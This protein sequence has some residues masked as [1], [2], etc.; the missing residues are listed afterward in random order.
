MNNYS[1]NKDVYINIG[2]HIILRI[3]RV[4]ESNIG[5]FIAKI[6]KLDGEHE[7]QKRLEI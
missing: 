2:L 1:K 6:W 4:L 7:G 3:I 5:I